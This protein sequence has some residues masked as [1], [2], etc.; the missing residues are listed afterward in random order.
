MAKTEKVRIQVLFS[1]DT[2]KGR[3]QDALYYTE[4]EYKNVKRVDIDREKKKRKDNWLALV[5][6]PSPELTKAEQAAQLQEQINA[7]DAEKAGLETQR[8]KLVVT[9]G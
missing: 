6:A 7:L 3:F 4:D 5:S 1:E 8:A 2:D 9:R